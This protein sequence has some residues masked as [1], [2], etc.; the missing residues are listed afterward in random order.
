MKAFTYS[1]DSPR[2]DIQ[3][4]VEEWMNDSSF[5]T[6]KTSGSTGI[7]KIIRIDKA[8]AKASAC[9]T[10]QFLGLQKGDQALMS[11]NPHT[12][13]GKMMLVRAMEHDLQLHCIR[14][15]ANPLEGNAI[16][17]DF[18]SLAPI[19]LAAIID[20]TPDQLKLVKH[21]I[22]GGGVITDHYQDKLKA[23]GKT[24]YQTFGMTETLSHIAMR[25]V[26]KETE[27]YY[28]A[29]PGVTFSQN[30]INHTLIVH[31]PKI[32]LPELT[33]NDV[34]ELATP[35]QFRWMGRAD[36]TI[37][38]GGVK[39]QIEVLEAQLSA[40][41]KVPFFI[42]SQPHD[43]L[44]QEI[45]II[46]EGKLQ[47]EWLKKDFYA[48]LPRYHAP[49]RIGA[50]DQFKRTASEKI[51]RQPTYDALLTTNGLREIL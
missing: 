34:V 43:Q 3:S 4:F 6:A 39:V 15:K 47:E 18:V 41:I 16:P 29:M 30:P 28:L 8:Y 35:T 26:G 24:V 22:V 17:Y 49:K 21:I 33:T 50:I 40:M 12:I 10:I 13:G 9:A 20:E 45:I 5:F 51:L 27:S 42:W 1:P 38:T 23:L 44:G 46:V 7:P 11:L 31:A 19:Q 48:A 37:N 25:Q 36:F 32:G 14:P 2:E